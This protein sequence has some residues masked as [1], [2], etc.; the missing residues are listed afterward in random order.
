MVRPLGPEEAMMWD[1]AGKGVSF[2]ALC[3]L[4]ATFDDPEGAALRAAGYLQ[5][6]ITA[7]MLSGAKLRR[8]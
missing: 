4:M 7:G 3:Q 6:W 5:S 8:C 2:A 1:E